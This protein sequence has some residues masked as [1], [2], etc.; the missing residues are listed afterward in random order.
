MAID[1][2]VFA[3]LGGTEATTHNCDNYFIQRVLALV[4][5][6]VPKNTTPW[7]SDKPTIVHKKTK[8]S[9]NPD[10]LNMGYTARGGTPTLTKVH[11]CP[12]Y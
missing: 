1:P 2:R 3:S 7:M 6:V 11:Q 9:V 5:N 12:Y 10:I 8:R 4:Q